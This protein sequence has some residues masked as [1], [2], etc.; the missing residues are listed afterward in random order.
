MKSSHI[1]TLD[2]LNEAF[3]AWMDLEY[4]ARV[5]GETGETPDARWRAGIDRVEYIDERQLRLAFRWRERRTP[6]KTGL[7]SLLGTRYQV[8][9]EL[10]RRR[11]DVYFDP[12]D[13]SEVE[14]HHDGQFVERCVPFGVREHRR[15][16]AK[17][18]E[19]STPQSDASTPT[20]NWLGHIVERRREQSFIEA[21]SEPA[22]PRA[23]DDDVVV[24]LLR[25]HLE[26]AVFDEPSVRDFLHRYGPFD[27]EL[28]GAALSDVLGDG[29]AEH[30]VSVYLQAIREALR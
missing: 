20:A 29:P 23:S 26:P 22:A 25:E 21:A 30:H 7:F 11:I 15:P 10:A 17:V 4:N 13:L 27:P 18:S 16:R 5:H 14:V 19:P 9:P 3:V 28:A 12:E 2:E 1:R 8:G 6:D 24:E